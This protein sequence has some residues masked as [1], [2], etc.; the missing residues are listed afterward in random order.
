MALAGITTVGEFHYLHHQPDGR[1]YADAQR[2]RDEVVRAARD[3]GLRIVLLRVGYARAGF[4]VP[5]NR[6]SA[7]F[8]DPDVGRPSSARVQRARAAADEATPR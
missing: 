4:Q 1:P 3:V 8:I 2:A 7:R 5:P 6:G